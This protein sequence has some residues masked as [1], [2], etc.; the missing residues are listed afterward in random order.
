[1]QVSQTLLSLDSE[2]MKK[3]ENNYKSEAFNQL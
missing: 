3:D 1:M 2:L